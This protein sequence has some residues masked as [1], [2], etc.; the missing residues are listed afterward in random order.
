MTRKGLD[1]YVLAL[2]R[3]KDRIEYFD[4]NQHLI[5][6]RIAFD[7]KG[8]AIC[9]YKEE[10]VA[11]SRSVVDMLKLEYKLQRGVKEFL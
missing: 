4:N 2:L 6:L 5:D 9:I 11:S 7:I 10:N 8:I 1:F 3:H